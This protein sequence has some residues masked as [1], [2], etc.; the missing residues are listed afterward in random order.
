[1]QSFE[2]DSF[3]KEMRRKYAKVIG[4][5]TFVQRHLIQ[6]LTGKILR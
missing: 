1:M 4:L 5:T 6:Y 3:A 2:R